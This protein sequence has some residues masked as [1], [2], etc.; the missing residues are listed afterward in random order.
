MKATEFLE[1]AEKICDSGPAGARSATSR[2]YYGVFHL[3]LTT[4]RS[5]GVEL[6]QNANSHSNAAQCL[7][8]MPSENAKKAGSLLGDLH[9]SRVKADYRLSNADAENP[10]A[11]KLAIAQARKIEGFLTSL[12]LEIAARKDEIQ[13]AM[14]NY[15]RLRG[16]SFTELP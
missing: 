4:M 11:A 13:I 6:S 7:L 8:A 2:A 3:A 16:V 15:C 10:V 5:T 9:G 14:M 12:L 1:L